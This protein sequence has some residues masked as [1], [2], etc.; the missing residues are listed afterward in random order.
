[1]PGFDGTGP[2]GEGPMTGGG[3]GYCGTGWGEYPNGL[4]AVAFLGGLP[5]AWACAALLGALAER[6]VQPT[7]IGGCNLWMPRP[8]LPNSGGKNA[9]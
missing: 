7:L 9:S 6:T 1:M 2:R 3:F 4:G 8:N 5:Q